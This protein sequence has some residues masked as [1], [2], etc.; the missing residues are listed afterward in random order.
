MS[1]H[2]ISYPILWSGFLNNEKIIVKQLSVSSSHITDF[3][4]VEYPEQYAYL[5]GEIMTAINNY[6]RVLD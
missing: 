6:L 5:K 4:F 3:E 1:P 2:H